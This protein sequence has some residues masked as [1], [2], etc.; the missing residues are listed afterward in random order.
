MARET[1]RGEG[2]YI[3]GCTKLK[4]YDDL[5][6]LSNGHHY[7]T[8]FNDCLDKE[9]RVL[10]LI[11]MQRFLKKYRGIDTFAIGL[12]LGQINFYDDKPL[13]KDETLRISNEAFQSEEIPTEVIENVDILLKLIK[14]SYK[15]KGK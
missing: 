7:T 3:E 11:L 2:K 12:N 15:K 5:N 8:N 13:K 4:K 6:K 10:M 14:T 9:D 1:Y